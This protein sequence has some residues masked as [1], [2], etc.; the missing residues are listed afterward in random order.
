MLAIGPSGN[1]LF[2]RLSHSG[3]VSALRSSLPLLVLAFAGAFGTVSCCDESPAVKLEHEDNCRAA[4][5]F[6]VRSAYP[7][8]L[9]LTDLNY[10][11][12]C[13]E[14]QAELIRPSEGVSLD[15]LQ[16]RLSRSP[17]LAWVIVTR[18]RFDG[19]EAL[20]EAGW[21]VEKAAFQ[22]RPSEIS[23]DDVLVYMVQTR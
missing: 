2:D 9:V 11:E 23:S 4:V 22:Q 8:A 6:V 13:G 20:L 19:I 12:S 14:L 18:G 7:E 15:W 1:T 16:K 5:D 3:G 17:T 10:V 21:L